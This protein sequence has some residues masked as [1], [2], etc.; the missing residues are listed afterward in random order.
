[1][2]SYSNDIIERAKKIKVMVMDVDG[3]LTDGRLIYGSYGDELKNFHVNDGLGIMLLR[4]AGLKTVILTAKASGVVKRRAKHL[5]IDKVY[6]NFHFK[7]DAIRKVCR[8]F[9]V[10]PEQVCFAGDD[11]IDVP[12]LKHVGLAVCPPNAMEE[13]RAVT[14]LVTR[15]A[16]GQGAVREIC[17]LILKAQNKWDAVTRI[18][19][20]D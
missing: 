15:K 7:G 20:K 16:G 17:D 12:A 18:Y 11:L 8:K 3:V 5:K 9:R 10:K 19:L 13:V 4:K 1:V 14:H 2:E 6:Q